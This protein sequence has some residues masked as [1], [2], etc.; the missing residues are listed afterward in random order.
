[1]LRWWI[2]DTF[3]KKELL[4]MQYYY[5]RKVEDV[6]INANKKTTMIEL[7]H[8]ILKE[9]NHVIVGEDINRMKEQVLVVQWVFDNDIWFML[10]SERYKAI[11]RHPRIMAS[12][13]SS[14]EEDPYIKIDDI[15][16]V[17]NDVGNGS[18]LMPYFIKYCKTTD[19]KYICG[20]LSSVDKGHFNRSEHFYKKHEFNVK[21]KS[22]CSAGSIKYILA[23]DTTESKR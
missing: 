6:E 22:D 2:L 14:Y 17:N 23:E 1:M 5:Q 16:V 20:Q 11:N 21:F 3:F 4:D 12:Y 9:K 15:L 8:S 18:I 19:A 7:V 10:Y 13:M